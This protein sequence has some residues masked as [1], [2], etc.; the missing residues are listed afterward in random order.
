MPRSTK[1]SVPKTPKTPDDYLAH[2]LEHAEDHLIS[3]AKLF[4][5]DDKPKRNEMFVKRLLTAQETVTS[6]YGEELIR[7][8]GPLRP[9]KRQRKKKAA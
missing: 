2:H 8:R 3:A 9:P 5:E 7:I 4:E 6:L 1:K